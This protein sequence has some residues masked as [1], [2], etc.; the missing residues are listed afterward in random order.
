MH[1]FVFCFLNVWMIKIMLSKIWTIFSFNVTI[2]TIFFSKTKGRRRRHFAIS[3]SKNERRT[4]MILCDFEF[5]KQK[6][7]YFV[8]SNSKNERK[9]TLRF[10]IQK[11]KGRLRRHFAISNLKNERKAK[12]DTFNFN[13]KTTFDT[14][15]Y[16]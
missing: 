3:N 13:L 4:K 9:T 7:D 11:T 10:R 12:N 2:L 8:I 14:L 1:V 6:E 5:K 15:K 16:Y